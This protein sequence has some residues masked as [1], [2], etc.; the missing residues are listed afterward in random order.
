MLYYLE[1]LSTED[2]ASRIGCPHGTVLSRLSRARERLRRRLDRRGLSFS[3]AFLT[4][5]VT[6]RAMEVLPATW[7]DTTVRA[8]F[9]FARGHATEAASATATA[10]TLAKGVLYAMTISKLKIIG[11]QYPGRAVLPL[12]GVVLAY[13][14]G[15]VHCITQQV[16]A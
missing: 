8:A 4:K 2:A 6:P 13:G 15:G 14:G 12:P 16:P 11:A 9:G 3:A 7:L 1:G 5:A 10:T